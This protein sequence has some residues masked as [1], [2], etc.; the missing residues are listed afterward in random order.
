MKAYSHNSDVRIIHPKALPIVEIAMAQ[1]NGLE[2]EIASKQNIGYNPTSAPDSD[3][4]LSY[5]GEFVGINYS[6]D[7]NFVLTL[8]DDC[9]DGMKREA[10]IYNIHVSN[11]IQMTWTFASEGDIK[12]AVVPVA[13]FVIF[14]FWWDANTSKWQLWYSA[15]G[16]QNV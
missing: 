4:E 3:F 13:C 15:A 12:P 5:F 8:N 9:K 7:A 2:A 14:E 6:D 10:K 11:N 1:V 16:E